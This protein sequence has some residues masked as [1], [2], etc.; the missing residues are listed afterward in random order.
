MLA[1]CAPAP[2]FLAVGATA[3]HAPRV[4]PSRPPSA[5]ADVAST[6]PPPPRW[7]L[8]EQLRRLHPASPRTPSE[9][10]TGQLDGEIL[11]DEGAAAYPAL[12][13]LRLIS[14]GATLVERLLP[15]GAPELTAYFA[16]VKRPPGYD[17]AGGDWEYLVL[18]ASGRIEQRG[19][20]PLCARCHADAPHDHLFGTG[21]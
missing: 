5:L 1:A 21:R 12:G 11:A 6:E 14:P 13:P 3:E 17:P 20:L 18:D 19:R 10:L 15:R 8:A 4:E 9:H 16:M 7:E 2:D